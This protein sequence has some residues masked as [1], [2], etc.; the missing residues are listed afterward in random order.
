MIKLNVLEDRVFPGILSFSSTGS[1]VGIAGW[2]FLE[3][4]ARKVGFVISRNC[5]T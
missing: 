2:Y 3:G 4:D 1:R 5:P